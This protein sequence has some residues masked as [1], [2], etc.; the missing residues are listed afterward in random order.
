ML[1]SLLRRLS[2]ALTTAALATGALAQTSVDLTSWTAESYPAV[3]GFGA[4][5]W[6]VAAGGQ[7]VKQVVNGQPTFFVSPFNAYNLELEGQ[8]SSTGGGDDDYL[9]FALGFDPGESTNPNADFL[10]V[11]WK[12]TNQ[13]F[14][15]GAPSCTAGSLA[16]VGLAVSRVKGIPTA[17]EFWGHVDLN[18][19]PC[20]T[21]SDSVTE[22]ARATTLGATG[23]ALNTVYKFK[24]TLT[25]TSLKVWVDDVLQINIS[26][27]FSNGRF[28]FYNFSQADVTY[29]A[30]TSSCNAQWSNYGTASGGTGGAPGLTLSGDPVLGSTVN[31]QIQS[32]NPA[33]TF[34]YL[35]IGPAPAA[36]PLGGSAFLWIALSSSFALPL[37]PGTTTFPYNIPNDGALCG[38][39]L[40]AQLAH[41][42]PT[43]PFGLAFTPGLEIVYGQ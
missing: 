3:S 34:G 2:L 38:T 26:G 11:D 16:K 23:W 6:N 43:A 24:F 30:Y 40:Y 31:V 36:V 29:A 21:A 27:L 20:S 5:V 25:A 42:D 28:A 41:L 35:G 33:P 18:T 19:A 12:R 14:D 10:L 7:S 4:G 1:S 8:I 22:L 32:S 9:G 39:S 37:Q 15:F 13:N 17:D